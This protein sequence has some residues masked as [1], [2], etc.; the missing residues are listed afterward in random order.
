MK[1]YTESDLKLVVNGASFLASGGGGS[2]AA[3]NNVVKNIIG[4]ASSVDVITVDELDDSD[5]LMMICGV[6]APD[7][8][9]M[10]FEDSPGYAFDLLQ[11]MTGHKYH[12]IFPIEVGAMNSVIPMLACAQRGMPIV[13]GDG[14]GRSVPQMDMC[15]Y[16]EKNFTCSNTIV[17]SEERKSFPLH[18]QNAQQLESQVRNV[19]STEL[20][21][22]GTTGTWTVT[23]ADMKQ[24][25][26]IV[27]GSLSLAREIGVAMASDQPL[28]NVSMLLNDFYPSSSVL[29]KK[30]TVI[31]C[32]NTVQDGFDVGSINLQDADDANR[33]IKIFFVNESLLAAVYEQGELSSVMM[34]PD[35][36]CCMGVDGQPMTNSEIANDY[37]QGKDV[38][39]SLVWVEAVK[40]I[41]TPEMW[42]QYIELILEKF[43]EEAQPMVDKMRGS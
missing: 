18:P 41:R 3:A 15:T 28:N 8:K 21:D 37:E 13:D 9:N 16:A 17:V 19:V 33:T 22:I 7:A 2:V 5:N 38:S 12:G 34:G 10:N 36:I 14:A 1:S 35:M 6:G 42:A 4:F 11:A 23:G 31:D 30:A 40:A 43:G 25:G 20:H 24:P 26:A 39:I 27:A 29:A 32:T